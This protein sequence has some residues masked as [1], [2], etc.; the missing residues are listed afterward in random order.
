MTRPH[1][2]VLSGAGMS[3]ESGIRTFRAA[4]G[5][6]E[7]HRVEDVATPEAFARD[8]KLVL[9]F[10]NERRRQVVQAQPN[11][12]HLAL[13]AAEKEFAVMVI[14]QNID[15]LHERAGSQRVLHLHGELL[16]ARSS[17]DEDLLLETEGRD[18]RM[19]DL[20]PLG[21]QL[22]PH[23]VWF[24]EAVP[25]MGVAAPLVER[26]DALLIIG[27]SLAVYPAAS[28]AQFAPA[29]APVLLVD[30]NADALAADGVHRFA[31]GAGEGVPQALQ[32]LREHFELG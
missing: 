14:T 27:T 11:A 12:G 25:A 9:R 2:V 28:L 1:L 15:D 22:R 31:L 13:A 3:A 10:Y 26:A 30:P 6:W 16:K 29:G 21:S 7:E 32:F 17:V 8:P 5:L 4:D 23:V 20:C 19:G 24:G 18:I